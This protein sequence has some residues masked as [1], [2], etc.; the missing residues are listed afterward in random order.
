MFL[1]LE[2]FLCL[3]LVFFC[4]SFS[5]L[6]NIGRSVYQKIERDIYISLQA[7]MGGIA[8]IPNENYSIK[9]ADDDVIRKTF[10][11]ETVGAFTISSTMVV[12]CTLQ[13]NIYMWG[14]KW[15]NPILVSTSDFVVKSVSLTP[16]TCVFLADEEHIA[17][18]SLV[19][20]DDFNGSGSFLVRKFGYAYH[21]SRI[22]HMTASAGAEIVG[23]S[24]D[25]YLIL[26]D[27]TP[28][29]PST[30]LLANDDCPVILMNCVEWYRYRGSAMTCFAS[31]EHILVL[32]PDNHL[33]SVRPVWE[34][35]TIQ[36][37]RDGHVLTRAH[38]VTCLAAS[39]VKEALLVVGLSDGT[40]KLLQMESLEVFRTLDIPILLE[41]LIVSLSRA[42]ALASRPWKACKGIGGLERRNKAMCSSSVVP[43]LT[44]AAPSAT[45]K[46]F[47]PVV[48]DVAVGVQYI[49]VSTPDAVL[50]FDKNNFSLED[51]L[52]HFFDEEV[53]QGKLQKKGVTEENMERA[54]E[55][56]ISLC[57]SN[58]CW[59][60]FSTSTGCFQHYVAPDALLPFVD[61]PQEEKEEENLLRAHCDVPVSWLTPLALPNITSTSFGR[62]GSRRNPV[63][64][65]PVTFGHP[66]KSTGYNETPWSEQ[67][68]LLK[69]ASSITNHKLDSVSIPCVAVK[70]PYESHKLIPMNAA[71]RVLV[72]SGNVHRSA[73]TAAIFSSNGETLLTGSSDSRLIGLRYPVAKNHGQ[74]ISLKGHGA[75]VL[76][77]DTNLSVKTTL[78]LS[79]GADSAV[80]IWK[81]GIREIPYVHHKLPTTVEVRSAKFFYTDK[82]IAYT[83]RNKVEVCKFLL[84]NGGGDLNRRRNDSCLSAP[85]SCLSTEAQ[86]ITAMDCINHFPTTVLVAASSNKSITVFDVVSEKPLRV[87]ANAHQR[88]IH[89]V[90]L[91]AKSSWRSNS[92]STGEHLLL[93]AGL[94]GAVNM[95]D[96]R[97][98]KSI[99]QFA[100]H[101]NSALTT[102]GLGI[103]SSGSFFAVGSED[104]YVYLYDV[105]FVGAPL[106][107]IPCPDIPTALVFHPTDPTLA[108]G[109]SLGV[110]Q[111]Y[112]QR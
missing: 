110:M 33:V 56:P 6:I 29:S 22:L 1:S 13:K 88:T 9:S 48:C 107:V 86:Y 87:M 2:L 18:Y 55:K 95:W 71:N 77:L 61:G 82:L 20:G 37:V 39:S 62:Q 34:S 94:D 42:A 60:S 81:P 8:K 16:E 109:T 66:I 44:S 53:A 26:V 38:N 72:T 64:S 36:L 90:M 93:T 52:V 111:F 32:S 35:H 41:K 10:T 65:K 101:K 106:D 97:Q 50:Y 67:Q 19:L 108:I 51:D 25:N 59:L 83:T 15:Q 3:E 69:N 24:T 100:L 92:A 23:M 85:V 104:R 28:R 14:L 79:A 102:L 68:K 78:L 112:G 27:C 70:E 4:F 54:Q 74:G 98:Q 47:D 7:Y 17:M 43:I 12:W 46:Y 30:K 99:R 76:S 75:G 96:L 49:V 80:C 73:V 45:T 58:G 57:A 103:A 31:C 11:T 40:V 63:E 5:L 105:R 91:C 84:D 89:K 21:F